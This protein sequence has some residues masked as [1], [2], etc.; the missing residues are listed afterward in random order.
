MPFDFV[1]SFLSATEDIRSPYSFRLWTAIATI[2]ATLERRVWTETDVRPLYPN[3]YTILTGTPASGKTIM[4]SI[5]KELLVDL[6][7][8]NRLHLGPDNPTKASFLDALENSAKPSINGMGIPIY[9][10]MTVLCLELGVLIAKYEKE[11][12]ADLTTLYDNPPNYSAPR[13]VSK[14]VNLEAPTVNILAAATPDAIGDIMPESAWGQG[15]T[16]RLIFVYGSEPDIYRDMFRKPKERSFNDLKE[17][18]KTYYNML[19]GPFDWEPDAQD[20]IRHWFNIEKLAPVPTY[21]RLVN[22]RGRR[23]EHA[24][25][26]AMISAVS[27]GNGLTVTKADFLRGRQWLLDAEKTMPDVFR[28]MAQKSDAQLLQ[29]CHH[30]AYSRYSRVTREKRLPLKERELWEWFEDKTTHEK[31][32]GLLNTLERTGRFRRGFVPGDW[33]PEPF[34]DSSFGEIRE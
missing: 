7:G 15:F 4:V 10:A 13:R 33:I 17:N 31:I 5:S 34:D 28:A 3:L 27:A 32:Q 2:A 18:L 29:D 24:M 8:P 16:S 22:Y 26:L 14:S 30:W 6:T 9:S 21:S 25:K 11:F 12:V 23:N 20:T 1:D 19:H